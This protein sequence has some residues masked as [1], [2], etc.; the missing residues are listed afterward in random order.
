[1]SRILVFAKAPQP[2][3]AKTRLAATLG[4]DR[5][6]KLARQMLIHCLT[7]AMNANIDRVELCA[8]PSIQDK[9]WK[10]IFL[11]S[12]LML[13]DQGAGDL[14][15]RLAR[16]SKRALLDEE[17]IFLIG[18]DCPALDSQ[19]LDEAIRALENSDAVLIP[20]D[21]GGYVL[22]GFKRYD[23]S[24]F[25]SINWSTP[26]VAKETEDRILALD[27]SFTK[28]PA[29]PDIDEKNDLRHLPEAWHY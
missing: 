13:S 17:A 19:R 16:A 25:S 29:L 11:P 8:S 23:S 14:G 5:A 4:P 9:S 28:L 2:G 3:L 27:W 12:G 10:D 24:L 7:E 15:E 6:A 26:S 21:D 18:T 1:M 20:A 22:F